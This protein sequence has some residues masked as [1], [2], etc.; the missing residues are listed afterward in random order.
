MVPPQALIISLFALAV[1]L[2]A[3][4]GFL[5]PGEHEPLLWLLALVPAF[6]LAYYRGWRG[7]ALSLAVSMVVFV[8][9][10]VA[11]LAVQHDLQDMRGAREVMFAA[12]LITIAVG[13]LAEASGR[14][15]RA[16]EQLA[17]S[18]ALTGLPNRR[19]VESFVARQLSAACRGRPVSAV[20][21]DLDGFKGLNDRHGHRVGDEVL[22]RVAR[23]L[24]EC[25]RDMDVVGRW[26]GEEF[27]AVLSDCTAE[28]AHVV[29]ERMRYAVQHLPDSPAITISAGVAE[30]HA[31]IAHP[32]ELVSEA[33]QALYTAKKNGRNRVEI[34]RRYDEGA[35]AL[36]G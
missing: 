18:D 27:L 33:D 29:A 34:Y 2:V 32:F 12:V 20:L 9:A 15:E 3:A 11:V 19:Y 14:R 25:Q 13:W 26:G 6:L 24:T 28:D 23:V 5:A 35:P 7:A 22:Q 8:F 31:G 17:F 10:H 21:L 4:S 36:H 1:P 16:A 30:Y